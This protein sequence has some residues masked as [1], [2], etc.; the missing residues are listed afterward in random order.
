MCPQI[1]VVKKT[2]S[3]DGWTRYELSDGTVINDMSRMFGTQIATATPQP[4]HRNRN[5]SRHQKQRNTRNSTRT[6]GIER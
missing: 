3:Q 6:K 1:W 5:I 2:V 4:Q